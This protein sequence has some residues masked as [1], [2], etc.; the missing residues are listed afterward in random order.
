MKSPENQARESDAP[1]LVGAVEGAERPVAPPSARAAWVQVRGGRRPSGEARR[2]KVLRENFARRQD[3]V[4][5]F[6]QEAKS[7]ARIAQRTCLD[8]T[9]HGAD[10]GRQL[11]SRWAC[12]GT[13]LADVLQ[14]EGIARAGARGEVRAGAPQAH[15]AH[16]KG[17]VHRD[18]E[19]PEN[20]FPA[21]ADEAR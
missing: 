21:R 3:V 10:E 4:A 5:R 13:D 8:V 16:Q 15:A 14:G 12:V 7:A 1:S 18:M 17:I 11:S 20:V 2:V 9:D 19:S 6:N